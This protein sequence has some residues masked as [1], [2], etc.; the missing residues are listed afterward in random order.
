MDCRASSVCRVVRGAVGK[1]HKGTVG[2][3]IP[4]IS[5]QELFDDKY[6]M[7]PRFLPPLFHA[8]V[9]IKVWGD[10]RYTLQTPPSVIP[11]GIRLGVFLQRRKRK[12]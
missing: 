11:N 7:R 9:T 8:N 3:T 5:L 6:F 2:R 10:I 4:C 12:R 1:G